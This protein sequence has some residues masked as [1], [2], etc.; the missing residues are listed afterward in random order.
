M[1]S[2]AL[3]ASCS[4]S[5]YVQSVGASGLVPTSNQLR[6]PYT[7]TLPGYLRSRRV[8]VLCQT[9]KFSNLQA[10]LAFQSVELH[11]VLQGVS[12]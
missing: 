6:K 8:L 4:P 12:S 3:L 11:K 1:G 10:K 5:L 2:A 9:L 7:H